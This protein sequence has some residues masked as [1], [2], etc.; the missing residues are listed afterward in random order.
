MAGYVIKPG[1][2][3]SGLAR[4]N[5][6]SVKAL[7][8]A[9]PQIADPNLI[10]AGATMT[11][12]D[13]PAAPA[14]PKVS[15][16][17]AKGKAADQDCAKEDTG[18]AVKGCPLKKKIAKA[19]QEDLAAQSEA[20]MLAPVAAPADP[21]FAAKL[22][23]ATGGMTV[24][25]VQ[26]GYFDK[27][28]RNLSEKTLK[29]LFTDPYAARTMTMKDPTLNNELRDVL[30]SRVP[31]NV[32]EIDPE[33]WTLLSE[34]ESS[35]HD[36]KNKFKY[37]SKDG[38]HMEAVFDRA[39]GELDTTSMYKGTFNYFG[40]DEKVGHTLADIDPWWVTDDGKAWKAKHVGVG[41]LEEAK[42]GVTKGAI[43]VYSGGARGVKWV[44]DKMNAVGNAISDIRIFGD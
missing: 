10:K 7:M 9:N 30:N 32:S 40:K 41:S 4:R 23:K 13:G 34:T 42:F 31:K 25:E 43:D 19:E 15:D 20:D 21:E 8:Q 22:A 2:T 33:K 39:T 44:G 11:V 24:A 18:G 14:D 28:G 26:Q 36:P 6:T 17:V 27:T 12:P 29:T 16:A 1:D 37:V 38:A 3:L 35:F 5:G